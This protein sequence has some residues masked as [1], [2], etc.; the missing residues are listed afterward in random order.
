MAKE[1]AEIRPSQGGF[2]V[3]KPNLT[4]YRDI[5][6]I[7][8][9]GDYDRWNGWKDSSSGMSTGIFW[10]AATFQGLLPFYYQILNPGHAWPLDW[11]L[12]NNM[13][14][15]RDKR[16]RTK[17]GTTVDYCLNPTCQDCRDYSIH[18]VYSVHFTNCLKP[19][20][21]QPHGGHNPKQALC[22]GMHEAWFE[23]R[24]AM[25]VSWGRPGRGSGSLAD[26]ALRGYCSS[27]GKSGYE[28]IRQPY[29][30]ITLLQ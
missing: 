11:C 25:E 16:L 30:A 18:D 2:A 29:G 24:S 4:I 28:P 3:L 19:W 14:S 10:G 13:N 7:V 26:P 8:L 15:P 5:K 9:N 23:H 22:R 12:H 6:R 17:N 21:C 20:T 27:Y 1:Y